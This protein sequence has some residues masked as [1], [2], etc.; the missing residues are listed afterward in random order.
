MADTCCI[1]VVCRVRPLNSKEIA[2]GSEFVTTFPAEKAVALKVS[3]YF[4]PVTIPHPIFLCSPEY[5]S[6]T[7]SSNRTSLNH[8]STLN[9]LSL[10][11]KVRPNI[12]QNNIPHTLSSSPDVLSGY[13]ATIF[14]Y[15]QTASGKTHTMEVSIIKIIIYIYIYIRIIYI[16]IYIY[17]YTIIL[18]LQ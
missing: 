17:I 12:Q 16:Y 4:L 15:G 9:Q 18:L 11:L 1:R 10:L 5:S 7:T 6:S 2:S 8:K 13:N 14:A 3:Q